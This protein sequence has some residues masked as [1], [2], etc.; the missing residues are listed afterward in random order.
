MARAGRRLAKLF[1]LLVL[2]LV[3]AGIGMNLFRLS[4]DPPTPVLSSV[5]RQGSKMVDFY[6]AHSGARVLLFDTGSDPLGR[7]LDSLLGALS[8]SRDEV[9]DVFLTHG[10]GDHAAALSLLTRARIHVGQKDAGMV[11][12]SEP[13]VPLLARVMSW[14]LPMAHVKVSDP[15]TQATEIAVGN[16]ESVRAWPLPGHTPGSFMYL[17]QRVLFVGDS[18]NF[19][20]GKLTVAVPAFS[21]DPDENRRSLAAMRTTLGGA[22]VDVICVGHGGCT[23]KAD[24]KKLLDDLIASAK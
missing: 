11:D 20:D 1:L 24:T 2:L 5:V 19:K 12:G 18:L 3:A 14:V 15:L 8:A 10:H 21:D 4:H 22:Q 23:P 6:G 16:G 13:A 7:G 9:T 17:W